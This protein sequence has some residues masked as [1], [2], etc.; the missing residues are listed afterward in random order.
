MRR[1]AIVIAAIALSGCASIPLT[2]AVRV[3]DNAAPAANQDPVRVIARRPV[4]GMSAE[5]IV[6]GFLS[7]NAAADSGFAIAREYLTSDAAVSWNTKAVLLYDPAQVELA[8]QD[9]DTVRLTVG[10]IGKLSDTGRLKLLDGVEQRSFELN[11]AQTSVGWRMTVP[12]DFPLMTLADFTRGY[13]AMNLWFLNENYTRMVPD[14]V[15]VVS[16]GALATRLMALLVAG[17]AGPLGQAVR[18]ALPA[19]TELEVGSVPLLDGVA[20]V[21]LNSSALQA[22]DSQRFAMLAQIAYTL[23]P[24]ANSVSVRAGGQQLK[25]V[26]DVEFGARR[27]ARLDPDKAP[28]GQPLVFVAD[29]SVYRVRG[30]EPRELWRVGAPTN[31]AASRD[32]QLL[33][34]SVANSL[35]V[36]SLLD[37][38]LLQARR[39]AVQ[40]LDFDFTGRLWVATVQGSLLVRTADTKWQSVAGLAAG[41][42]VA[43]LAAAPDGARLAMVVATGRGLQLRVYPVVSTAGAVSLGQSVRVERTFAEVLDVDWISSTELVVA[44]RLGVEVPQAYRLNLNSLRPVLLPTL[45]GVQ[46]V[47]AAPKQPVCGSTSDG[48]AWCYVGNSWQ[49]LADT[50][51]L[52]YAG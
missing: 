42:R 26:A 40:D 44:A 21:N 30:G 3:E 22:V 47:I 29:G 38:S 9:S 31:I 7:A 6:Q 4:P 36:R 13:S 1:L 45:K 43:A 50:K 52:T 28:V 34:D 2:D 5:Q 10:L 24:V 49:I 51:V 16:D 18:S 20:Q 27:F 8:L 33:A 41:E 23:A 15:W 37:G 39:T 14:P 35:E 48:V 46:Q 12:P 32:G 25:V 17:P 11:L 19:D